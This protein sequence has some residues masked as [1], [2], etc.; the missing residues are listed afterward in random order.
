MFQGNSMEKKRVFSTNDD[1]TVGYL[2]AKN[3]ALSLPHHI[4]KLI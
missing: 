1:G 3:K 4:Y 2:K